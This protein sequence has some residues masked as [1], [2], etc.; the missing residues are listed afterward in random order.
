MVSGMTTG[1]PSSWECAGLV[2]LAGR[3]MDQAVKELGVPLRERSP[4]LPYN[5]A[6]DDC[7]PWSRARNKALV[8]RVFPVN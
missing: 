8:C 1:R 5:E 6:C 3:V 7:M 2:A 4:L